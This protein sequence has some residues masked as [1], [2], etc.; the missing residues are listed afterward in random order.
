MK[1]KFFTGEDYSISEEVCEF[2]L[3]V[4]VED[5]EFSET[6]YRDENNELK[7]KITIMVLYHEFAASDI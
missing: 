3:H 7:W 4:N 2:L 5:I 1:I 6:P